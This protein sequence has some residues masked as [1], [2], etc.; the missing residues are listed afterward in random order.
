[1]PGLLFSI[2]QSSK[3]LEMDLLGQRVNVTEIVT[4]TAN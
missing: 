1:M 4:S 2:I 3:F